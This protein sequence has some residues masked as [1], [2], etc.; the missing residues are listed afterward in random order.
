VPA[1]EYQLTVSDAGGGK[2]SAALKVKQP[3]AL[4]LNA[5]AQS[6]ASTGNPDGKALAEV[7][8]GA[9]NYVYK[10]DNGESAAV[11]S[12][13]APGNR[14]VTVTDAN[15]CTAVAAVDISENILPLAVNLVEKTTIKCGGVDKAALTAQITGGK[16]PFQY[17]WSDPTLNGGQPSGLESGAYA[18]TVTDAQGKSA[19]ANLEVKAPAPLTLEL[20]R[21]L[22]ATTERSNDGKAAA[23]YK[24]GTA[25]VNI[26]WDTKQSTAS[27]SKLALGKHGVTVTDANGCTKSVEFETTKRILPELTG[28]IENGQTIRMRLLNFETNS[29]DI[30]TEA[31]L[32]LDELYDFL[33][34]NSKVAIEVG[35][36]TNNQPS[37]SFADRLSTARA[38]AVA[39]YLTG[40]GIDPTRVE[41]KGYGKRYPI[42]SNLNPEGRNANQRVEIKILKTGKE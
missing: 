14:S 12:K 38:K 3:E 20:T 24:G 40:K 41:H 16:G 7:K 26:L 10:W 21:N 15:G 33:V 17:Q 30:Q 19:T 23:T 34:I 35:G 29:S 11:A 9:G 5:V 6:P 39:D 37:D 1:G 31:Y 28:A 25:P 42:A 32:V 22:G 4:Y 36:H 13:L 27:V 8:G 18:V 2:T